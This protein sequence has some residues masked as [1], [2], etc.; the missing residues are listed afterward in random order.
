[1]DHFNT[2]QLSWE[3]VAPRKHPRSLS[4]L[5][6]S[7][8]TNALTIALTTSPL[9]PIPQELSEVCVAVNTMLPLELRTAVVQEV[10]ETQVI[11]DHITLVRTLLLHLQVDVQHLSLVTD[12]TGPWLHLGQD[13]STHLLEQ[14]DPTTKFNLNSLH[15]DG[16]TMAP[17]VLAEI[18]H[19]SPHLKSIHVAGDETA[20][21]VLSYIKKNP[22]GLH[23]LHLDNCNV[24]DLDVVHA[25]VKSYKDANSW[26]DIG[27][28]DDNLD[29]SCPPLCHLIIQSPLVTL[30]GAVVLLHSLRNLRNLQY[31]YWN[32]SLCN[33]FVYLK[34][35]SSSAAPFSLT[36]LSLWQVTDRALETLSLCPYLQHLMMECTDPSL[37]SMSTLTH[38]SHLTSLT[39]RLVPENLIV[40][41]VQAIGK[42]LLM[43][44]VEF[45]ECAR[46]SVSWETV[47][48][49][50]THC[51]RL[52]RLELHHVIITAD[53][54]NFL[55]LPSRP[56]S[57]FTELAQMNLSGVVIQPVLL[58]RLLC[59]NVA[60]ETL[61][62]DVN[63]DALTD[64]CLA[65]LLKNNKLSFLNYIY[66]SGGL[67]SVSTINSLLSLPGL[68]RLSLHLPRFPFIP[69]PTFR[70][71]QYRLLKGNYQCILENAT[72][73]D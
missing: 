42:N 5:A 27:G 44:E 13:Y 18:I 8:V 56:R 52:Q 71:L 47:E 4:D 66:L 3:T 53:P 10:V 39:L 22:R 35:Q 65:T 32:S 64:A 14:L 50:Q 26:L 46:T 2:H 23:S 31:S 29:T 40:A 6:L 63:H 62:L 61:V 67:L 28:G 57:I 30:C 45:E 59:D 72:K 58:G 37:T 24:T 49:I 20:S 7:Q 15:L 11:H 48:E 16:V 33:L 69:A 17:G 73:S 9:T 34:Q 60:L 70:C 55:F 68:V 54:S 41:A 12:S 43:L 21:E 51:S 38:L 1:M 25:L 19:R 36:S